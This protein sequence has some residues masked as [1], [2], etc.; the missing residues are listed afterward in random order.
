MTA[1][2]LGHPMLPHYS[3]NK[4]GIEEIDWDGFI[5]VHR[6]QLR[7]PYIHTVITHT[8]TN[9]GSPEYLQRAHRGCDARA[10]G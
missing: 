5:E 10:L 7:T 8:Q 1:V 9:R 4:H 3:T 2:P 6:A